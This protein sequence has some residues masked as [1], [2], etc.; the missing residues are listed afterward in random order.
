[1]TETP[2]AASAG[3]ASA[4]A[5]L[6]EPLDPAQHC[7]GRQADLL[8][9]LV[10]SGPAIGLERAQELPVNLVQGVHG[11]KFAVILQKIAL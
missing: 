11:Y 8:G 10:V 9:Q 2:A 1:M 6:F 4:P 3:A 7:A 5:R